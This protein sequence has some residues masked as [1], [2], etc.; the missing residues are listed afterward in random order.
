MVED[1][2]VD[3]GSVI[4]MVMAV[5]RTRQAIEKMATVV[6]DNALATRM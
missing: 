3:E 6:G 4:K 2:G 5:N 1:T